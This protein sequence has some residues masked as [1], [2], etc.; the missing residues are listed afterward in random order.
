MTA[1]EL[2]AKPQRW[3]PSRE[4]GGVPLKFCDLHVHQLD[5]YRAPIGFM[6]ASELVLRL[7]VTGLSGD[8]Y[9]GLCGSRTT[10]L[11][12]RPTI[13]SSPTSERSNIAAFHVASRWRGVRQGPSV[14]TATWLLADCSPGSILIK[15]CRTNPAAETATKADVDAAN[16][17]CCHHAYP[18]G[19]M[20]R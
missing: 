10:A 4:Q 11:P 17:S 15:A 3:M 19:G 14:F 2:T 9:H 7:P 20:S 8:D 1:R 16:P 18:K 6:W 5:L 12:T 13:P